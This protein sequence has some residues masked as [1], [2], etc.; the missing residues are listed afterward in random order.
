MR[1]RALL[2]LST[3]FTAAAAQ[4]APDAIPTVQIFGQGQ[5]RQVQ[6]LTRSDLASALP[7]TSPLKTLEKLPGVSF[8][9]AD[10]FGAYEWSTRLSVRGFSQGQLGFTLDDIPL[11]N[12][13]YGN[14][15]GLHISRAIT[16]ENIR[17]VDLA[18]GAGSV[19]TAS[20]SNLGGTVQFFSTDPLQAPTAAASQTIGSN[21]TVRTFVRLDSGKF[22]TG[23]TVYVSALRQRARKWKGEGPQDLD[24]FNGKWLQQFGPHQFSAFLNHSDRSENDYQDLSQDMRVRLGWEWDNYAPDWE[25]ALLAARGIYSGGVNNMD[26]AY[27]SARG[28]RKDTLGGATIKLDGEE[29]GWQFKVTAYQHANRGQGHWYTPYQISSPSIPISIRTSEYGV[30]RD[31][32]ISDLSWTIGR[33]L[34]DGGFWIERNRHDLTRNYYAVTGPQDS[35]YFLS[36]PFLT[37]FAQLFHVRTEQFYLQDT[38]LLLDDKL[39]LNAGFKSPRVR[40]DADSINAARAAGTLEAR[41]NW[42]PQVGANFELNTSDEVFASVSRNLRAFEPGIYGQFSQSQAAFDENGARLKPETSAT[43]DLGLRYRRGRV[44]GSVSVYAA[45]FRDR[46]L[47]VAT[48]AGVVGCPNTVVNVGKVATK[49]LEAATHLA[50]MRN[51]SWFN[52]LTLNRSTYVSD[53]MD[54]GVLVPV[55]GKRVVDTP[56]QLL[57]T[58]LAYDDKRWFAKLSGKYTSKRFY[59]YINDG[60]VSS[61]TVWELS[62]GCHLGAL[63]LQ[64]HVGNLFNRRYFGTIGSNQFVASDPQGTFPTL[65]VGAPREFFVTLSGKLR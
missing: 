31:G 10:V 53:Y 45:D 36:D 1:Q 40:I 21:H 41:K 9:S 25:R 46:L 60:S 62:S 38:M 47:T 22:G 33:H 32:L 26:D 24:Q 48:C 44:T 27:Y 34:L 16:P 15:N 65:L 58:E 20:T 37:G 52:A 57:H 6:N 54:N 18:Q 8:Q 59:T 43:A 50:F 7:G 30:H 4:E 39:K 35:N 61:Y 29:S 11:G 51:W 28:L 49:G 14:N 3:V 42:L 13:S 64:A 56:A 63:T 17:Q 19:G 5:T 23:S 2:I 12:M 55:S